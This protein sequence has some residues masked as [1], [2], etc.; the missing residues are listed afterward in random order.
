MYSAFGV[1]HGEI[2]KIAPGEYGFS[3]KQGKKNTMNQIR[4]D[5]RMS[6]GHGNARHM[7]AHTGMLGATGAAVGG[8][9]GGLDFGAKG[10]ALGAGFGAGV[11]AAT[12]ALSGKSTNMERSAQR[13]IS[14]ALKSGDV[15]RVKPGERTTA[16]SN[17]IVKE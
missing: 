10:A 3:S 4:R 9:S 5:S 6:A 14:G 8:L 16:F 7:A 12:G 13:N 11:G 17:R 15:R 2:S 1:D